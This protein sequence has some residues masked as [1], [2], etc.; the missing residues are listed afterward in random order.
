MAKKSWETKRAK[1]AKAGAPPPAPPKPKPVIS[2]AAREADRVHAQ[3]IR[4][5]EA[6]EKRAREAEAAAAAAEAKLKK[7][8]GATRLFVSG[9]DL[10]AQL[11]IAFAFGVPGVSISAPGVSPTARASLEHV[12]QPVVAQW[13]PEVSPLQ[14]AIGTTLETYAQLFTLLSRVQAQERAGAQAA[15]A[16]PPAP[17]PPPAPAPPPTPGPPPPTPGLAQE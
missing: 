4:D 10:L 6:A 11:G 16:A 13:L 12:W 1:A 3:R 2:E 14:E 8:Q 15:Q 5:A 9:V 17:P 7:A